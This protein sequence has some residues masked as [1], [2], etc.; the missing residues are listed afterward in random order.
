MSHLHKQEPFLKSLNTLL[1]SKSDNPSQWQS[2]S[3]RKQFLSFVKNV[4][5]DER[6]G[7]KLSVIIVNTMSSVSRILHFLPKSRRNRD[8]K[9][10]LSSEKWFP[11]YS[12]FYSFGG[13][14]NCRKLCLKI[15]GTSQNNV[16]LVYVLEVFFRLVVQFHYGHVDILFFKAGYQNDCCQILKR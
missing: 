16:W 7:L 5:V 1:L 11:S 2:S 12:S 9:S 14:Y 10:W 6:T 3:S 4:Q 15:R 8:L 13:C